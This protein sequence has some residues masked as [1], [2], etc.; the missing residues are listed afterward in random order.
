MGANACKTAET[1]YNMHSGRRFT[2]TEDSF[3]LPG[4][5]SSEDVT[6]SSPKKSPR[7]ELETFVGDDRL[8]TVLADV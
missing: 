8:K 7:M 6:L 4:H 5:P 1:S 3:Q 2:I